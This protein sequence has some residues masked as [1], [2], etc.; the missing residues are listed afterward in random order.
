[1]LVVSVIQ[2]HGLTMRV[3]ILRQGSKLSNEVRPRHFQRGESLCC[4]ARLP[5]YTFLKNGGNLFT[6]GIDPEATLVWFDDTE[7]VLEWRV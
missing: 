1:M 2:Q 4:E 7:V 5:S 6:G 3:P